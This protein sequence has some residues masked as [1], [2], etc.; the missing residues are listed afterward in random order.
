MRSTT[1]MGSNEHVEYFDFE[2][3]KMQRSSLGG[4]CSSLTACLKRKGLVASDSGIFHSI[5]GR[6]QMRRQKDDYIGESTEYE[7]VGMLGIERKV[8]Q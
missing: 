7:L 6:R 1:W 2:K 3:K 8:A 5:A 4:D